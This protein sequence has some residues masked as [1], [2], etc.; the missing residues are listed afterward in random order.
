MNK[1]E[2]RKRLKE[3]KKEE[4]ELQAIINKPDRWQDELV[5]PDKEKYFFLRSSSRKGLIVNANYGFDRKPEYAFR[6][7]GQAEIIK[8]KILL[9]QEMYAFAYVKNN[10]WSPDWKNQERKYGIVCKEGR[11]EVDWFTSG[12]LLVFGVAVKSEEI[13]QEMLEEFGAR[14]EE[15]YNKQY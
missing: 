10:W 8:E 13:V 6:I 14:I 7:S 1:E 15:V 12:N 2:A 4:A 11:A 3:I 9:M 5:Q